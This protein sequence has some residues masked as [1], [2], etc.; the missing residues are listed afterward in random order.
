[1]REV[2]RSGI[3]YLNTMTTLL[4]R[5]HNAHPSTGLYQAAELHFWWA[6]PRSTDELPQIFWLDDDDLPVAGA[7]TIDFGG[8]TTSLLYSEPTSVFAFMP[9]T[10]PD[11]M[12]PAV[13]RA[14]EHLGEHGISS[15]EAESDPSDETLRPVL[16]DHGFALKEEGV[17]AQAWLSA[18]DR[19]T[20]SELG[21]GYRLLN[22]GEMLNRPHHL[23][24]PGG[25]DPEARLRQGS[26]YRQDLDLVVVD[27]SDEVAACGLFWNDPATGVGVVEPMRTMDDHQQR[28]LARHILTSG[29]EL[30]ARAGATR[31]SLGYDPGNLAA[32]HLYRSTGFE[33]HRTNDLL[34][35]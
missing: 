32:G 1:M 3:D 35:R 8:G 22:R 12:S 15:M 25:P 26:L 29:I 5:M 10:S 19:P 2:L 34:R 17:M 4:Q 14:L 27:D 11:F 31:I 6:R 9:D 30:L 33:P 23:T 21:D 18:D 16:F 28:G 20:I 24:R 7:A 13:A